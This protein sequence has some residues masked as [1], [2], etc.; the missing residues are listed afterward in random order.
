MSLILKGRRENAH[1]V[2]RKLRVFFGNMSL[3]NAGNC[4]LSVQMLNGM[5]FVKYAMEEIV[6]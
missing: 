6:G 3:E 2:S 4:I 5:L 1:I